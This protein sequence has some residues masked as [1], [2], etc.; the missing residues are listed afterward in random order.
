MNYEVLYIIIFG[1]QGRKLRHRELKQFTQEK[2]ESQ[3]VV[4][5]E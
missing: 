3:L 5:L 2:G 1:S 4:R